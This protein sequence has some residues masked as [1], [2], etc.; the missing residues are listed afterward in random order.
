VDH[1]RRAPAGRLSVA[2]NF[3]EGEDIMRGTSQDT[4]H[5]GCNPSKARVR[6]AITASLIT[7][8]LFGSLYGWQ[9]VA[10]ERIQERAE[11]AR[12]AA[13]RMTPAK[14]EKLEREAQIAAAAKAFAEKVEAEK[15]TLQ[16]RQRAAAPW[17]TPGTPA[18][19]PQL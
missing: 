14:L 16:D 4:N 19:R 18:Y 17:I 10:T 15:H 1:F 2:S 9:H 8:L 12:L 11:Q 6:R 3:A 5:T 13:L 7:L